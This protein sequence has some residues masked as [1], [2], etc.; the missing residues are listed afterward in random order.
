M[1]RTMQTVAF[2]TVLTSVVAAAETSGAA[3][4]L[5]PMRP[6]PRPSERALPA[7]PIYF[8]DSSKGSDDAK[9]TKEQPWKTTSRAL[10]ELRPGDTL[11]LRGGIHRDRLDVRVTGTPEKPITIR[12]FPG[13]LVILDGGIREFFESPLDAWEPAPDGASGEYRSTK[14]YPGIG[15]EPEGAH[16]RG[17]FAE[18]MVPFHG[19]RF[20]QDLR[21]DSMVWDLD[22]KVG[23]DEG[24]Y[25]GPGVFYDVRTGRFHARLAHTTIKALGD[26]N[27]RG[28]T[29]PRKVPLVVATRNTGAV[30]KVDKAHDVRFEDLVIRGSA[31]STVEVSDAARIVFDGV[32]VYGGHTCFAVDRTSGLRLVDTA[33]RGQA[34]P[35][36]FRGHLKYRST[37]SRLFS[38][39]HWNPSARENRDFE[40]LRCEFTD[41]VDGVFV[42]NVRGVRIHHSLLDNISDDGL[43]LT[44]ATAFDGTTPGGDVHIFQNVISRCL[45]S[46]AFGVGHGRQKAVVGG[47]QTGAGVHVYR[48]VFDFR[49]PVHY[50]M[51]AD[52]AVTDELP[53]HGRFAGDH[54]GPLWESMRVY[55]NTIL[56]DDPGGYTYATWGFGNHVAEGTQWRLFNNVVC[57]MRGLPGA[58]FPPAT[59]D[60]QFD[61]NLLWSFGEASSLPRDFFARFRDSK[62]FAD[63]KKHYA[64]GWCAHDRFADPRFTRFHADWH[65][66]V[67]L[68]PGDDSP[69]VDAGVP[70]P[71][72]W[73]DP[74][75]TADRGA[76]DIGVL[77]R[78][79]TEWNVGVHNRLTMFGGPAPDSTSSPIEMKPFDPLPQEWT[80]RSSPV[81]IVHGYPAFDLPLLE[82]TIEQR[83]VPVTTSNAWLPTSEY[84]NFG[85]VALTGDFARAGMKPSQYSP[86]DLPHVKSFLES[87]GTLLLTRAATDVFRHAEAQRFLRDITGSSRRSTDKGL[88]ILQPKHPWVRHLDPTL[89][90][91]T[92]KTPDDPLTKPKPAAKSDDPLNDLLPKDKVQD[93]TTL[94]QG[95]FDLR[96][97]V[98]LNAS[99]GERIL[100][101]AD[102][103]TT[104]YRV[105]IGKGQL[106]YLG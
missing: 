79:G 1:F 95:M 46:F 77:P 82:F 73:P 21:D 30:V 53:S 106:I 92:L 51:P 74:L 85:L 35:W 100:G 83:G 48:N 90:V 42:G 60:V 84:A 13:E 6:L 59:A 54:G 67:N 71:S 50:Q 34:A 68:R 26:D 5:R 72:E 69:A 87:G 80:S 86:D 103:Q 93:A 4:A 52:L 9:G 99:R 11:C 76:P 70:L 65:Q 96:R 15:V 17:Y 22:N 29:D 49:R 10:K 91:A 32:T 81:A 61:G 104:L 19:Y 24:V 97:T 101:T 55:H 58:H 14:A 102:G 63:S 3:S 39:G 20:P 88:E 64:A 62:T 7:G 8:V 94:K 38:A 25:C 40:F 45:T 2:V 56:A 105:R 28:E 23:G 78:D 66:P 31:T 57:Q 16:V 43:F 33:C 98:P 12:A 47:R 27:Y 18:A 89:F 37:E 41:S 36:T 75:H 44:A